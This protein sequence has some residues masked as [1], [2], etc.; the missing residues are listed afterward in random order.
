MFSSLQGGVRLRNFVQVAIA[1]QRGGVGEV[2]AEKIK[3]FGIVVV[4]VVCSER[5]FDEEMEN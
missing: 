3:N 4:F 2:S 1:R 5:D